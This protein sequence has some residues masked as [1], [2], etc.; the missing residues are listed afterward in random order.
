MTKHR[1]NTPADRLARQQGS[2]K[3]RKRDGT[4]ALV[5]RLPLPERE[6]RREAT[7]SSLVRSPCGGTTWQYFRLPHG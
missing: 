1:H 5:A 2:R 4:F 3:R 6:S 7:A